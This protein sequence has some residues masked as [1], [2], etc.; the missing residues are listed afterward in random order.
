[1][2]DNIMTKQGYED[3]KEK[4]RRM[5]VYDLQDIIKEVMVAAAHGDLSENAEYTAAKEKKAFIETRIR[6]MEQRL[7]GAK[8]IDTSTLSSDRVVF[9][10]TVLLQDDDKGE[11]VAYTIVG[12]DEA[13][14]TLGKISISSPIARALI[15]KEEGDSVAVKTPGGVRNYSITQISFK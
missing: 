3:L 14:V 2:S 12:V 11:E 7:S 13:D 1:M 5:T 15:G 10:A 6:E 4:L 8:V 9:G